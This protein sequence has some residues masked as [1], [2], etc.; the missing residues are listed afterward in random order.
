MIEPRHHQGTPGERLKL[1]G[2]VSAVLKQ[3]YSDRLWVAEIHVASIPG[4]L[5]KYAGLSGTHMWPVTGLCPRITASSPPIG[6][7]GNAKCQ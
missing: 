7:R 5:M 2:G 4:Y 6:Q 1:P 3:P